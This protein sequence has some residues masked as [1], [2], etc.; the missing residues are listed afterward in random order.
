MLTLYYSPRA[1]SMASH[2]ALEEAGAI[3][4]AKKVDIFTGE[5]RKSDYLAINPR[6]K[7]PALRFDDGRVLTESTAILGWI[8]TA[9]PDRNMLGVDPVDQA[10]T[11]AMCAWLSGT[12]HPAFGQFVHPERLVADPSAHSALKAEA[13]ATFWRYL[14]E[15]DARLS[16]RPWIMG[17]QF[18]VADPYA[19]VFYPWGRELGLPIK[20]LANLN[21]MKDRL[22]ERPSARRALEREQSVLLS[23]LPDH[24]PAENIPHAGP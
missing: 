22:I 9:Y 2:V 21:V 3:F 11:I 15:L 24:L 13:K 5:Q 6:A 16:G 23:M 17:N 8:G 10:Q 7:V 19:L 4:E 18:T 20:Q 14:Q 1:C 12:V